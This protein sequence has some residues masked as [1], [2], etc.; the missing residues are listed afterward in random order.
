MMS[1]IVFSSGCALAAA[2]L[3]IQPSPAPV[4]GAG[5]S[6]T[7]RFSATAASIATAAALAQS[8]DAMSGVPFSVIEVI[9]GTVP[10]VR[11]STL[12]L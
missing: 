12:H 5:L 4:I 11:Y 10:A 3:T 7:K 6:L 8:S 1:S 2:A 9:C